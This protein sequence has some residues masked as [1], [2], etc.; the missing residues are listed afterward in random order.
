MPESF[1]AKPGGTHLERDSGARWQGLEMVAGRGDGYLL[2]LVGLL[3]SFNGVCFFK[4]ALQ[5]KMSFI[6][7]KEVDQS[8]S[9]ADPERLCSPF[10]LPLPQVNI[11]NEIS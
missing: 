5:I 11:S 9:P 6:F 2:K 4:S 7:F 8:S 3:T 1:W 10:S